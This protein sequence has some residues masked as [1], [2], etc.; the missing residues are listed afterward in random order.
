MY[1][2]VYVH[3]DV[4]R[5]SLY[6]YNFPKFKKLS[7]GN[8]TSVTRDDLVII[9][10]AW[11]P[12]FEI[13]F[14]HINNRPTIIQLSDGVVFDLNSKAKKN[15][16][17]GGLYQ[18]NLFDET[19][20]LNC[21]DEKLP[22]RFNIASDT[23]KISRLKNVLLVLGNDF[24]FDD[25][26]RDVL[27]ALAD[28]KSQY[29]GYDYYVSTRDREAES[30]FL[31]NGFKIASVNDLIKNETLVISTPSTFLI[32]LSQKGF[33]V[34]LHERYKDIFF[35]SLIVSHDRALE[36][37]VGSELK[38]TKRPLDLCVNRNNKRYS[39]SKRH[40]FRYLLGDLRELL[41]C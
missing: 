12:L 40:F 35:Q 2:T 8:I 1:K 19:I 10:R 7:L 39:I 38:I 5:V 3:G 33:V 18:N 22:Y 16:R 26:K 23:K 27:E 9:T 25:N 15:L 36:Q 11:S 30:Y 34:S 41:I 20:L 4:G 29:I 21:Y 37:R 17:Y 24:Y 32:E 6:R 14:N 13:I 31:N 28:I